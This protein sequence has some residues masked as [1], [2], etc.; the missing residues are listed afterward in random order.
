M[1]CLVRVGVGVTVLSIQ[2]K[3]HSSNS[4][5]RAGRC[6]IPLSG[7]WIFS[8]DSMVMAKAKAPKRP[9]L[10]EDF[11]KKLDARDLYEIIRMFDGQPDGSAIELSDDKSVIF[12]KRS[13]NFSISKPSSLMPFIS[14]LALTDRACLLLENT[15]SS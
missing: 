8:L 2:L 12:R 5:L 10:R 11:L 3:E 6:Q 1:A 13:R 9:V 15:S 4:G 7:L 14:S